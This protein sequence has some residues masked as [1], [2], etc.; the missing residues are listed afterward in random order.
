MN[1]SANATHW[2][3]FFYIMYIL[4]MLWM[5]VLVLL[6]SS[7]GPVLMWV[8]LILGILT[9]VFLPIVDHRITGE[10][11]STQMVMCYT[12][13]TMA[14]LFML[15]MGDA[16]YFIYAMFA[17]TMVMFSFVNMT[18]FYAQIEGVLV[19]AA[20]IF[21]LWKFVEPSLVKGPGMLYGYGVL[22]A[23]QIVNHEKTRFIVRQLTIG[24]EQERG[25]N[26]ML[27][28]VEAKRRDAKLANRSKTDFLS[29]MSHEIR[30]PINSILGMN[31][32]ILREKPGKQISEYAHNIER[33]GRLLLTLID[34]IL[35]FSK[36]ESGKM[37]LVQTDYYLNSMLNDLLV[38]LEQRAKSKGLKLILEVDPKLPN[39]LRGDEVRVRQILT[40]L[41]T[42]AVKYTKEGSI[43]FR[44][45]GRKVK[46]IVFLHYEVEDTGIGVSEEDLP[47]LFDTFTRIYS[48]ETVNTEGSGLGLSITNTL[49]QLMGSHLE[50]RSQK[51]VGSNFFFTLKQGVEEK[52]PIGE[53]R[54]EHYVEKEG[55]RNRPLVYAPRARVLVVD[56]NDMNRK[57][58]RSLLQ[59]T[60]VRV[61]QASGGREGV[62]MAE[63]NSY[64]IIFMDHMMPEVNGIEAFHMIREGGGPCKTTPILVLTANTVNGVKEQYLEEGFDS[65]LSKPIMPERLEM[66]IHD[67]LKPELLEEPPEEPEEKAASVIPKSGKDLSDLPTVD[68]LDWNLAGLHFTS[69]EMLMDALRDFYHILPGEA[70]RLEALYRALPEAETVAEYRI[71]VHSM[72]SS[73]NL[74]GIVPLAGTAKLLENAAANENVQMLREVTPS[75]LT[76]WRSYEALLSGLFP[77][78]AAEPET[79]FDAEAFW[80]LFE[81]LLLASADLNIDVLDDRM[82]RMEKMRVPEQMQGTVQKLRGM[83]TELDTDG[84]QRMEEEVRRRI[85]SV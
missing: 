68:G 80:E 35:D 34:D 55:N 6:F 31:E 72:K 81:D 21:L 78:A 38:L 37:E 52:E 7:A 44:V 30:T 27:K 12:W 56:D 49:L 47:R 3:R 75:F 67:F 25:M 54:R 41:L 39:H 8:F 62:E 15:C 63:K 18:L 84:I 19:G 85:A 40:N 1:N 69:R 43:T 70:D 53:F 26:D 82:E 57:V 46:N 71:L 45:S 58:F 23:A 16:E 42:N 60:G 4:F 79:A 66:A 2:K 77:G 29:N 76:C 17:E 65:F 24:K 22:I 28:V 51:G 59:R 10:A 48:R 14:F 50:V 36:I 13:T 32:L 74:V 33:S 73:A 64:D 83:V 20:A 11:E 5:G 61:D 9:I